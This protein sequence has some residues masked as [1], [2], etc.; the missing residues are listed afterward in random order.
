MKNCP[1]SPVWVSLRSNSSNR[2]FLCNYQHHS[3]RKASVQPYYRQ[4]HGEEESKAMKEREREEWG[5]KN[6][7]NT[8]MAECGVWEPLGRR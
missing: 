8:N 7:V 3:Q 1:K 2:V 6:S 4:T 5:S